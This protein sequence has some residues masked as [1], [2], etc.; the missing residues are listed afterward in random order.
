MYIYMYIAEGGREEQNQRLTRILSAGPRAL[1]VPGRLPVYR[2]GE[3][4]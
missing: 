3:N 2:R 1:F 4:R